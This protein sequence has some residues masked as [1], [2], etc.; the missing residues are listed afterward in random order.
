MFKGYCQTLLDDQQLFHKLQQKH[1]DVALIDLMGNGC[2]LA[3]AHKLGVPVVGFWVISFTGPESFVLSAVNLPSVVAANLS[4]LG[5]HMSFLQRITNTLSALAY[6]IGFYISNYVADQYIKEVLP[7]G[8]DALT[9]LRA[10]DIT[11][12]N[13]NFLST[14]PLLLPP[15]VRSIGCSQCRAAR[16]L[17]KD[18]DEFM[19]SSGEHGV[20]V[21]SLG[22]TMY[23][24]DVI[25]SEF[26]ESFIRVFGKLKQKVLMR[27]HLKSTADVPANVHMVD[28]M[29]QRDVLGH[30]NTR[31]FVNHCGINS[32]M[33]AIYNGVPMLGVPIFGDQGENAKFMEYRG[34]GI[35]V[36]K[37]SMTDEA[38]L[39]SLKTLL[40]NQT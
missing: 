12:V 23:D 26:I 21:F 14:Q 11:L 39:R 22:I 30:P 29:P 17:S 31:L 28:W 16:P 40:Y 1:F 13:N 2:G 25:P 38:L 4:D 35:A 20:V 27:Y 19:R 3:L 34:L 8:P 10:V 18:L 5:P 33:E 6:A 37:E 32:V 24:P 7:N 36:E 9:L 15:N